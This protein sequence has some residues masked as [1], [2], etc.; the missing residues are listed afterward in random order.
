[1]LT[2][3]FILN[4]LFTEIPEDDPPD[5]E[6]LSED[7]PADQEKEE[8]EEEEEEKVPISELRKLR[9]EA[10]KSRKERQA[11][12][13][14]LESLKT[15]QTKAAEE[16]EIAKLAEV[17]QHKARATKA[18][19]ELAEAQARITQ[20]EARATVMEK[21]Q[22]VINAA[23]AEGFNAP[24]HAAAILNLADIEVVDGEVDE[25]AVAEMVADLADKNPYLLA[26]GGEDE[27]VNF[28]GGAS[29]PRGQSKIPGPKL[30]SEGEI[31][32]MRKELQ[33]GIDAGRV[34]GSSITLMRRRIRVAVKGPKVQAERSGQNET[35]I[36]RR[37]KERRGG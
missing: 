1:M 11:A 4:C 9:R 18:Q 26:G 3:E 7:P 31:K 30:T 21:R 14:E 13:S 12:T 5:E 33:D 15:A 24:A 17:D 28:G 32:R 23:V 6:N 34:T 16:A 22:A 20:A 8:A 19:Q 25:E 36:Q 27:Q 10:A 2:L 29:N 35:R 37:L